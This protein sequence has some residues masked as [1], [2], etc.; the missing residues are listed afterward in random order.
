MKYQISCLILI[1]FCITSTLN[2]ACD[3]ASMTTSELCTANTTCEWKENTTAGGTCGDTTT[4]STGGDCTAATT[5]AQ[6]DGKCFWDSE[7]EPEE[8]VDGT[9][10]STG[11]C[12][13][14]E[15]KAACD[16][17]CT[18]TGVYYCTE[19]T[20]SPT[21]TTTDPAQGSGFGLKNSILIA[22]GFFL[23]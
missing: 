12:T 21:T 7:A 3:D 5:S 16:A 14:A 13:A 18:W 22:L 23:F 10:S 6:C 2:T 15:T 11:L 20:T 4:N 17:N 1:I 19:K 9:K 8:C